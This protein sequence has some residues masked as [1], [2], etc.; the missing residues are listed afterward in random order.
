MSRITTIQSMGDNYIYVA[1]C[2]GRCAF[3]VDPGESSG[4]LKVLE[5]KQLHLAAI[6]VTHH[7]TD[8]IGGVAE[9]KKRTGCQVITSDSM[10]MPDSDR[11]VAHADDFYIGNILINVIAT[12]GH[13]KTSVCYFCKASQGPAMVFT[14][15]TM[16]I[17]GCGRIFEGNPA[18][19]RA[20]LMRLASLDDDTQVY[21]GHNYT[22]ENYEFAISLTPEDEV[23]AEMYQ[24][25][26]QLLDSGDNKMS[27][28]IHV[29]KRFNP[30]LRANYPQIAAAV[31]LA[32][33]D[34][35]VVFAELR[36]RKDRF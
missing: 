33:A 7:H 35:D 15:D 11:I 3:A 16:F 22:L 30:F 26:K 14:G 32:N 17:N 36:A 8:H 12:P 31:G 9:L 19:M 25:V 10:N 27:S 18:T 20:S 1:D 23:L 21:C 13:T 24:K 4:V 28:T 34:P 2:G 5:E 6:L 29:E